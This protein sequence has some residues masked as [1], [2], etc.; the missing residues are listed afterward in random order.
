MA[1]VTIADVSLLI[2]LFPKI[3]ALKYVGFERTDEWYS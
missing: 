1:F 2:F 3:L